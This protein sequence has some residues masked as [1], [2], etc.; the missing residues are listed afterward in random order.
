MRVVLRS[1]AVTDTAVRVPDKGWALGSSSL[2]NRTSFFAGASPG[3]LLQYTSMTKGQVASYSP[4]EEAAAVA[5]RRGLSFSR[6][7]AERSLN[8]DWA[9]LYWATADASM[10]PRQCEAPISLLQIGLLESIVDE[11]GGEHSGPRDE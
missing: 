2:R 10:G 7:T 5:R 4:A 6:R 8:Q 1:P 11:V 3:V 9:V